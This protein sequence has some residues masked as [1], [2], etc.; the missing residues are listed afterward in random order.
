MN[1]SAFVSTAIRLTEMVVSSKR[2]TYDKEQMA[3][4]GVDDLHPFKFMTQTYT[5]VREKVPE[6]KSYAIA[7]GYDVYHHLTM[8]DSPEFLA[9][10]D[11]VARH[12]RLKDGELGRIFGADVFTS[13]TNPALRN[14]V[15]DDV[16]AVGAY[17]QDGNL[18]RSASVR[19]ER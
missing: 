3:T 13:A 16:I 10:L 18:I 15:P 11:P 6:A 1:D 17:D 7:I 12:S 8:G 9:V 2:L 4:E 5:L 14:A 19:L